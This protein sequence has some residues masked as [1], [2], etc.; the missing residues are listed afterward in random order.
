M[1]ETN[2]RDCLTVADRTTSPANPGLALRFHRQASTVT[3]ACRCSLEAQRQQKPPQ[4]FETHQGSPHL[5]IVFSVPAPA[6]G[7]LVQQLHAEFQP[8]FYVAAASLDQ[9]IVCN[10]PASQ[11]RDHVLLS[12]METEL[13]GASPQLGFAVSRSPAGRYLRPSGDYAP[14]S[15]SRPQ[16][17]PTDLAYPW[18][19]NPQKTLCLG[20]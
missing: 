20:S 10:V 18:P 1:V 16:T 5:P 19:G 2:P 11:L 7:P 6:A 15:P 14:S 8:A 3:S 12:L 9:A 17:L 4:C 13:A